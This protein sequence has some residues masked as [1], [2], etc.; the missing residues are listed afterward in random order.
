MMDN[1]QLVKSY[2]I[3]FTKKI[4]HTYITLSGLGK[5][6]N[7]FLLILGAFDLRK[8]L[9]MLDEKLK[10]FMKNLLIFAS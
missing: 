5:Y 3:L 10:L 6:L 2:A 4:H 7:I 9:V 8:I 1:K